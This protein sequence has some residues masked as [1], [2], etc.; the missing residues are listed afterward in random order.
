MSEE[1][2]EGRMDRRGME[3]NVE[4]FIQRLFPMFSI[5]KECDLEAVF[6]TI[7][8][9]V[10][11][12]LE[13]VLSL[14]GMCRSSGV[15]DIEKV[16]VTALTLLRV[17]I[18]LE[19]GVTR[20]VLDI[21]AYREVVAQ[22]T[23]VMFKTLLGEVLNLYELSGKSYVLHGTDWEAGGLDERQMQCVQAEM[24]EL[25]GLTGKASASI[26][27]CLMILGDLVE[28]DL[29]LKVDEA[30]TRFCHVGGEGMH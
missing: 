25:V 5:P 29:T 3:V 24:N 19:A 17:N 27:I 8:G 11:D 12:L 6:D 28:E 4:P 9:S 22:D 20:F 10:V 26:W 16:V 23:G 2:L 15:I 13:D 14:R 30:V 7:H 18:Q 1:L 21:E